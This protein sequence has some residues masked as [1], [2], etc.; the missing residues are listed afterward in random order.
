LRLVQDYRKLNAV[1]K[2]N[3]FPIPRIPDLIDCLSQSSIFTSLDLRW[4]Y[5]NIR[6]KEGNEEKAAFITHRGLF[7]PTVMYFGFCNAP[8]T[9]QQMMNEVLREEIATGHVVVYIDDILIF[10]DDILLHRQ[11]TQRVLTK[12]RENNL[13]AKPEKCHFEQ[14]EVEFLGLIVGKNSIKM[15]PKKVEGVSNWPA[16]TKVKHIQAFL[17]LANFYR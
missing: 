17:G 16:P 4:G 11:L 12:L 10:T 6:I 5:N 8:L 9:F 14:K 1:T 3:K 15:D 7:E 2:K 13:Y